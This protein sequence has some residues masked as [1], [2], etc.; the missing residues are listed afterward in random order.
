MRAGT[1]AGVG[2]RR[3]WDG[4]GKYLLDLESEGEERATVVLLGLSF[5]ELS[6]GRAPAVGGQGGDDS[7][8][9]ERG[10]CEELGR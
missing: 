4:L 3:R 8:R 9:G 2:A 1:K 7:L 10:D 5:V 6:P